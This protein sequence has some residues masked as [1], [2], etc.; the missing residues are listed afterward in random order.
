MCH[1]RNF[2]KGGLPPLRIIFLGLYGKTGER[3]HEMLCLNNNINKNVTRFV[4]I[5]LYFKKMPLFTPPYPI[6]IG[7]RFREINT[8]IFIVSEKPPIHNCNFGHGKSPT[9]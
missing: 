6:E 3:R 4:I 1:P 8:S 5:E 7:T 2:K 9:K